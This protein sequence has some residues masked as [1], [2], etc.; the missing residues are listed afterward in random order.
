MLGKP[1]F[2]VDLWNTFLNPL[3]VHDIFNSEKEGLL[4]LKDD[5]LGESEGG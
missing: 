4:N 3:L 5:T 1:L 2:E